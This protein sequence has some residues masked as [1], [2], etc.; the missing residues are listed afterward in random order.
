LALPVGF[1]FRKEDRRWIVPK[2]N[3][4]LGWTF[5]PGH[6]KGAWALLANFLL[7]ILIVVGTLPVLVLAGG[8][9]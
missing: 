6:A 9:R 8:C 5:N 4:I 1:Q 7:P 2:R 3:P